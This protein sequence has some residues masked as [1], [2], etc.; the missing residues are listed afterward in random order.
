VARHLNNSRFIGRGGLRRA[1][2]DGKDEVE[3]GYALVPE[4]W[5]Q[6]LAT[7]LALASVRVAF[8]VLK[9]PE[10]VSFTLPTNRKSRRVMEKAGFQYQR[11]F[12]WAD[13]PHVLYR[14]GQDAYRIR[15]A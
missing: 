12:I 7:E 3:V 2:I 9:V 8:D 11:D 15:Q 14:L 6:G 1:P 10:I 5:G 4:F 13:L